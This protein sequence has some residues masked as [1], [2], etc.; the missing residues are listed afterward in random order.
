M[1]NKIKP[2][3]VGCDV[4]FICLHMSLCAKSVRTD[5]CIHMKYMWQ[6]HGNSL[7]VFTTPKNPYCDPIH[8]ITASEIKITF[9]F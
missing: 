7:D 2:F 9:I 3:P 5:F 1:P 4:Y 6:T 8:D